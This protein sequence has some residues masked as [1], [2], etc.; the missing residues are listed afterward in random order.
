MFFQNFKS[1]IARWQ[2]LI[3]IVD[4]QLRGRQIAEFR[5][6]VQT[7]CCTKIY[8]MLCM[9]ILAHYLIKKQN[10]KQLLADCFAA[11]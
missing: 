11:L 4:R 2:V 6:S 10:P 9:H 1:S 5:S 3:N 7:R 8:I